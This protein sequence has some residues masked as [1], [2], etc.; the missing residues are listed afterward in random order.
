[1]QSAILGIDVGTSS[2][3]GVVYDRYGRELCRA[4]QGY[5]L[6]TPHPGW[7][8]LDMEEVWRALLQVLRDV[9]AATTGHTHIAALALAAQ[10][11]SIAPVD[12]AGAPLTPMLTWLDRR[13]E[14]IVADWQADGTAARIRTLSG[15]HPHPGLPIAT[16][17]WLTR[18]APQVTRR[19]ARYLGAHE[20]LV[21]RL[22]GRCVTDLSEGAEMLLLDQASAAWS[23]E[24]CALAGIVP[25]QLAELAPAGTVTGPLLP[26]VVAATGLAPDLQ[27][28]VGGQDQCCAALGMGVAAPGELMLATGTAWV[29]TALAPPTPVAQVPAGMEL[30]YHVAPGMFTLS[31]LLGGFGA[32]VEWWLETLL[33]PLPPGPA[34]YALFNDWL[35][36]SAPG[37][38]G[39]HCLPVGGSA[40]VGGSR[41]GFIGLRLDHTRADMARALC[42]G[43]AYEVRWALDNLAAAGLPGRRMWMAGGATHSPHWPALVADV[44]GVPLHVAQGA[45]WPARGAA[46]LAGAGCGLWGDLVAMMHHWRPPLASFAPDARAASLY[47]ARYAEHRR[48]AAQVADSA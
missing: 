22:T 42:E 12:A 13:A 14:S 35:A 5:R 15:W 25:A 43:I 47:A 28:V 44:T 48:L 26:A 31:Q 21:E 17:A 27:V 18:H 4:S 40:Q 33:Q 11:G 38:Q 36:A 29:L 10:A 16:I 30:N 45:L 8:E 34:R 2:L 37:A 6:A 24:L 7:A 32:A 20:F 23:D 19:A 41:G 3:K 46:L 39:L 1:M 9:A